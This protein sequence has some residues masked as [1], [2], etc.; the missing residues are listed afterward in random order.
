MAFPSLRLGLP[1]LVL[2]CARKECG[3]PHSG[4]QCFEA[5]STSKLGDILLQVATERTVMKAA[6]EEDSENGLDSPH[7]DGEFVQQQSVVN[8]ALE[9]DAMDNDVSE[10][11]KDEMA[12]DAETNVVAAAD[13]SQTTDD[14]CA[15]YVLKA[16]VAPNV[17]NSGTNSR[18]TATWWKNGDANADPIQ[19]DTEI[20]SASI[21]AISPRDSWDGMWLLRAPAHD[22]DYV[23]LSAGGGDAA[24][25]DNVEMFCARAFRQGYRSTSQ[26][27]W[28]ARNN[29]GWCL[30]TDQHDGFDYDHQTLQFSLN[31]RR[32]C[33]D[34]ITFLRD[35]SVN[36]GIGHV[37]YRDCVTFDG[38]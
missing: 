29:V 38:R 17:A 19:Y 16:E 14:D 13:I 6:H 21:A 34:S 31:G 28:G 37:G 11:L 4:A 24:L 25:V 7:A 32:P 10:M 1:M 35:G 12:S 3:A 33:A 8:T 9:A 27:A 18:I 30:S 20:G 23:R 22:W 2:V 15:I 36:C 26:K 5:P